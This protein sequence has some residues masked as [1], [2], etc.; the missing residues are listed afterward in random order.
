M[1][2]RIVPEDW[3]NSA[4]HMSAYTEIYDAEVG[5]G[6]DSDNV[7]CHAHRIFY[8]DLILIL[9]SESQNLLVIRH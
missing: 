1:A 5:Q 3:P 4:F 2:I 8:N 7:N 6:N 9:E